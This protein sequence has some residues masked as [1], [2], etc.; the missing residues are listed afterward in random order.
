MALFAML[1]KLVLVLLTCSMVLFASCSPRT[2]VTNADL[3]AIQEIQTALELPVLPVEFIENAHMINSPSGD[4]AVA[5]YRDSE[6]RVFSV[7]PLTHQVVEM[8]ARDLLDDLPSDAPTLSYE[9]LKERAMRFF[10]ATLPDF[11][12]RQSEWEYEEGQKG[13]NYFFNWYA[14]MRTGDLNRPFAQIA[15]HQS[16]FLFAFYNTLTIEE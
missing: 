4:L 15:L 14:P 13:E 16:G 3:F 10:K 2:A 7:H 11:E 6:G 9:Q 12:Q 8:D 5:V 1:K